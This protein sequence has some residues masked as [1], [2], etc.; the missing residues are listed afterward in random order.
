VHHALFVA[1]LVVTEVRIFKQGFADSSHI[2]VAKDA[3]NTGEEGLGISIPL[4]P[5]VY[6]DLELACGAAARQLNTLGLL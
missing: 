1:S 3:K 6:T 2:S 4:S 5:L